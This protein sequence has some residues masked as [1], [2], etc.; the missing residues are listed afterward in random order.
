MQK[1][2]FTRGLLLFLVAIFVQLTAF[3]QTKVSGT[4]KDANGE[5][6]IGASVVVEGSTLGAVTD[7]DGN[8]TINDVSGNAV[9]VFSYLGF[10]TQKIAVGNRS[11]IDIVLKSKDQQLNE[12]VVVG[13]GTKKIDDITGA[14]TNVRADKTNIG[15]SASSVNQMLEG[16]VAGVQFKQNT[17]QP[18]G[19]G[20]TIIRG[21]NSLFLSTDPLYVV[22]GFIVNTPSAP[23][24]GSTFGSPSIDPLNSINPN[25]IESVAVLKDA[26]ATAIYGSQGSNGVII[27]TTKRG[28]TGKLSVNYDG[29]IGFQK[30]SKKLDTMNAQEYMRYNNSFGLTNFLESEINSAN[31]TD[32][33]EEITRTGFLQNHD[34]SFSGGNEN[35]KFYSSL[36]YYNQNGI[37]KNSGMSRYS[38]RTNIEYRQGKVTFLS[39]ISASE[40]DDKSLSTDGTKRNSI[41]SSALAFAP[42]VSVYDK[43]G[44]YNVDPS[45]DF[46]ANPVSMLDIKDKTTTDKVNL[47]FRLICSDNASCKANYL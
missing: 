30:R 20:K 27:I 26:A 8:Y 41:I 40:I 36:G 9:L 19:G 16:H 25:D 21:R 34:I 23:G 44:K 28:R 29:Y 37:I 5:P 31:T 4:V 46:I 18:G 17:A 14:V 42:Q 43:N 3:A 35:L 6:I 15:G 10:E 38:G 12:V 2:L 1:T 45:N 24:N 7:I 11:K 32:W 39:N 47:N 33:Q 22:D 13:Y